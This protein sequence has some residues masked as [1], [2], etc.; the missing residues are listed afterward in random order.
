M[1]IPTV[2]RAKGKGWGESSRV[3]VRIPRNHSKRLETKRILLNSEK[4][5]LRNWWRDS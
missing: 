2:D 5:D 4:K 1:S 3:R